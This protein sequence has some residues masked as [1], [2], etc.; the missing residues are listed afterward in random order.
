MKH[1]MLIVD[2]FEDVEALATM[3]VLLRGKEEV[4]LVSLMGRKEIKSKC[5]RKITL[6]KEISEINYKIYDSVILPGGPGSFKIMAYIP[7]VND[8]IN[9]FMKE[10][11]LVSAICAAPMIIGKLHYLE[12]KNFTVH[13]GFE[14][15]CYNGNYLKHLGV[16]RDDN[17]IT[18]KSMYYSIS[19]GL[20]I[21][22]YFY[23]KEKRIALENACKGEK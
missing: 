8:I 2:D 17:I 20:E 18:A 5:G 15:Y 10:H 1:L 19:F 11:K 6:D 7:I 12:N 3:D 16:V 4:D 22:E 21:Y 9:Y 23:G 14:N 13:P